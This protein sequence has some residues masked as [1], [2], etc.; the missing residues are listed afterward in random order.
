MCMYIYMYLCVNIYIY[1][2]YI[3]SAGLHVS[4]WSIHG[5]DGLA[6][7]TCMN[8][9]YSL[10]QF[11][12]LLNMQKCSPCARTTQ[13]VCVPMLMPGKSFMLPAK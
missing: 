7:Q 1:T 2:R 13:R 12:Y 8:I 6:E 11:K 9:H 3:D 10:S 5:Q 4:L